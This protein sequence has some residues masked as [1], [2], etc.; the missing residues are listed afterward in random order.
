M[1][2]LASKRLL[3]VVTACMLVTI[4][5]FAYA[6]VN[7]QSLRRGQDVIRRDITNV[8]AVV[9]RAP[10]TN[11]T[12]R[13]CGRAILSALTRA[14]REKLRGPRGR[15]GLAGPRGPRGQAGATGARGA[16]GP[17]GF[18]GL[19]GRQGIGGA[20]GPAGSPGAPGPGGPPLVEAPPIVPPGQGG[21]VP[22]NGPGGQGPPGQLR[23][24]PNRGRGVNR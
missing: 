15:R 10:C 17:R 20:I 5:S 3:V 24:R 22:G 13:E 12:K 23:P 18:T 11:L 14:D 9:S 2:A 19:T 6:I 8:T 4:A 7:G 21:V 16:Q 1:S